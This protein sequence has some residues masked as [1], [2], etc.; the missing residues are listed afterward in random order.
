MKNNTFSKQYMDTHFKYQRSSL[1]FVILNVRSNVLFFIFI[2]VVLKLNY[3]Q[4]NSNYNIS[5]KFHT[6]I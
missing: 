5:V 6:C 1:N 3:L 4:L 2:D